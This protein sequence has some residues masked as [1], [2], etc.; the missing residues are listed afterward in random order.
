MRYAFVM[1]AAL[2]MALG[3]CGRPYTPGDSKETPQMKE[4]V[5]LL[6]HGLRY[7]LKVMREKTEKLPS[8]QLDVKVD[9]ENE[10][11]KD[12]WCDVQ[13][14]FRGPD[15]YEVEKTPWEPLLFHRRTLT[16]VHRNSLN[17]QATDYL[18]SIRNVK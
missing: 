13:I 4:K 15:G 18:L 2:V 1:V 6:D 5:L 11:D 14:T 17:A 7:Y 10:E 8:G 12:V 9:I 3:A 16:T